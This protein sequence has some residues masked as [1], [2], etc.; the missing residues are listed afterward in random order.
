MVSIKLVLHNNVISLS[1]VEDDPVM[2]LYIHLLAVFTWCIWQGIKRSP[3]RFMHRPNEYCLRAKMKL[4][5]ALCLFLLI[6]FYDSCIEVEMKFF[7]KNRK[8]F[9]GG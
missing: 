2:H 6:L 7:M 3:L 9:L 5:L 8:N 4:T 1:L